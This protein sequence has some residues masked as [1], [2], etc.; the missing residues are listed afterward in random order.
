MNDTVIRCLEQEKATL[1]AAHPDWDPERLRHAWKQKKEDYVSYLCD[2]FETPR[3]IQQDR[4]RTGL[5][6]ADD[7][8]GG[9]LVGTL[10]LG[11][12]PL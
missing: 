12:W 6:L 3:S 9:P 8:Y 5:A 11:G 4:A 1:L 2:E 10:L 7:N